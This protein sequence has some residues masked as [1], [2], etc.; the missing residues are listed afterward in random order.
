MSIKGL[1]LA[2][3][4]QIKA[5]LELAKRYNL[6]IEEQPKAKKILSPEDVFKLIKSKLKDY[7]KEH[8]YII[9]LNTRNY[10]ISEI[11]IGTLNSSLVH[12]REVFAEAIRQRANSIILVHNHPSGDPTP[13]EDDITI[14]KRLQEAGKLLGIEILDHIIITKTS[15]LSFKNSKLI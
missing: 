14:T 1:G 7:N 11:S 12:P 4:T 13:S 5:V 8:F 9:A 3:A 2:K 6:Q 15:Y 10:V